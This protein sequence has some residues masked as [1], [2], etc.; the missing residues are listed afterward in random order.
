MY[1]ELSRLN[2][3]TVPISNLTLQELR[4]LVAVADRGS[5]SA[6]A[7]ACFVTQP[8]LSTQLKKLEAS[9]GV[10]LVE[11]T[12]KSVRMTPVGQRV[13]ERARSVLAQCESISELARTY[14]DPFAEPFRVGIIATL[15]PYLL[16]TLLPALRR[17]MPRFHLTIREGLTESLL[18]QLRSHELDGVLLALPIPYADLRTVPVFDESFWLVCRHDHP[19]AHRRRLRENDLEGHSVL[20]LSEGHCLRDQAL[21]ICGRA[22]SSGTEFDAGEACRATSLETLRHLVEAGFGC[23][24]LPK[25]ALTKEVQRN[26]TLRAIRFESRKAHR[27]IA[28]IWRSSFARTEPLEQLARFIS[29]RSPKWLETKADASPGRPS[30][31]RSRRNSRTKR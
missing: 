3:L 26:S 13:V 9:L 12:N 8:T 6:A 10:Q 31:R 27:T 5:F 7:T 25:L 2:S 28:L 21:E 20:L 4:Y 22:D 23:T 19:L 17:E 16:P 11:R 30:G 1:N 15:G 14:S 29:E 18:A 24:L